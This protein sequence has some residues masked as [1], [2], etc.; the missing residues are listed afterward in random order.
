[1]QQ[2]NVY[3]QSMGPREVPY[4]SRHD[5]DDESVV[6]VCAYLRSILEEEVS[7]FLKNLKAA[8]GQKIDGAMLCPFCPLRRFP[9]GKNQRRYLQRHVESHHKAR[10]VLDGVPPALNGLVASGTK[11]LNVIIAMFEDDALKGVSKSNYLEASATAVRN[12]YPAK[13]LASH[14]E[15]LVDRDL[16]LVL[17]GGGPSYMFAGAED[18]LV[19]L[20]RVGY[21]YYDKDFADKLV[22]CA[23]SGHGQIN[24]VRNRL[25]QEAAAGE[26]Y[27]WKLFPQ[28]MDT[29][30]A[31]L[32][33]VFR[34]PYLLKVYD[35]LIST[36][37]QKREF[38][39]I[40]IDGTM[41]ILMNILGQEQIS[42][43]KATRC[44]ASV[45]DGQALR[46]AL[47]IKGRTGAMP[48]I[49]LIR[50]ESTEAVA[51]AIAGALPSAA[52][53]QVRC[54]ATD[55][56]SGKLYTGLL[57]VLPAL[58]CIYLDPVHLVIMYHSSKYNRTGPGEKFLRRI[59]HKFCK[60]DHLRSHD[61]WGPFYHGGEATLSQRETFMKAHVEF[62]TLRRTALRSA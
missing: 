19:A 31:L 29:W 50:D 7:E 30:A 43:P 22:R 53:E 28:R 37:V 5:G 61:S 16:I 44:A 1:M 9:K 57:D 11:Q 4:E 49:P 51:R 6:Y 38:I 36:C 33:D 15:Q 17:R 34:Q 39:H 3:E 40:S 62:G 8:N 56:P 21:T 25:V 18:G 60:V 24:V 27:L 20:R 58:L 48:R 12:L 59:M 23:I 35:E 10:A 13:Y 32:E 41:K 47:T 55:D 52:C 45:P 14:A 42:A 54:V 46:R 2:V 26:N